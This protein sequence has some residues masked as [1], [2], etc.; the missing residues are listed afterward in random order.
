MHDEWTS[1]PSDGN[2]AEGNFGFGTRQDRRRCPSILLEGDVEGLRF[3][4]LC[5]FSLFLSFKSNGWQ[6]RANCIKGSS[7]S[8]LFQVLPPWKTAKSGSISFKIR[9][10]EPNGLIMY[11]RSGAP[12]RVRVLLFLTFFRM[13]FYYF[14]ESWRNIGRRGSGLTINWNKVKSTRALKFFY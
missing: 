3:L 11:S 13:L 6:P 1:S 10:N 7:V 5:F 4:S 2:P 14:L 12:T 9:T 8:R